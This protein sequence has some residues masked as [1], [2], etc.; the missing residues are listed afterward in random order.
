ML[1]WANILD[2]ILANLIAVPVI[3]F[4]IVPLALLAVLLLNCAPSLSETL[5][6]VVDVS[7]GLLWRLLG[8][9]AAWPYAVVNHIAASNVAIGLATIG[10]MVLFMPQGIKVGLL[11]ALLC[12]PLFFSA[13]KQLPQGNVRMTLLDVGQGLSA[14][15]QT[16]EHV[17][18]F[19]A[20]IKFSAQA[21]SGQSVLLPFLA[22]QGVQK[23][24]GFSY[25]P[26][27]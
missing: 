17:L 22:Q 1:V 11:G 4:L 8:A 23:L 13:P 10:M 6:S 21:D 27:R 26:R 15:I 14:V 12:L 9:L 25:Q 18:V 5:L 2:F 24:D 19:D 7:L 16:A 3:G 20:G